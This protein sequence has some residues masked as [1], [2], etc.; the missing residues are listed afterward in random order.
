[1]VQRRRKA[2]RATTL[3][4]WLLLWLLCLLRVQLW[5]LLW[6]LCLLR[7]QPAQLAPQH[8][9]LCL[10]VGSPA[11]WAGG[12]WMLVVLLVVGLVRGGGEGGGGRS[13]G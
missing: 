13:R 12:A 5:L 3:Q 2:S 10:C 4:L 1:M 7:V 6:L 9:A 11:L 8:L